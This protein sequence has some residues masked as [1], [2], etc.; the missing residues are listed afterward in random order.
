MPSP[1]PTEAPAAPRS[2]FGTRAGSLPAIGVAGALAVVIALHLG[3]VDAGQWSGDEYF[4]FSDLRLAG[5]SYFMHRLLT[6]SPRPFSEA[7]VFAYYLAVRATWNPL[8]GPFLLIFWAMLIGCTLAHVFR[9]DRTRILPRLL[10]G[11]AVLTSFLLGHPVAEMFYWPMGAA[12]YLP[13]LA[14]ISY[15]VVAVLDGRLAGVGGRRASAVAL[16]LAAG[17]A[18]LGALFVAGLVPLLV[19]DRLRRRMPL[20]WW[21]LVPFGLSIWVVVTAA[22]GRGHELGLVANSPTLHHLWPS[23]KAAAARNGLEFVRLG[24]PAV[25]WGAL[26]L[27]VSVRILT[28]SG[29]RWCLRRGGFGPAPASHLWALVLALFAACF[30]S[31]VAIYD[32][33]GVLCCERQGTFRECAYV[34]MVLALAGLGQR[35]S[36][37]A[38]LD[39]TAAGPAALLLAALLALPGRAADLVASYRM[40][41]CTLQARAETWR[42][43]ARPSHEMLFSDQSSPL[44]RSILWP[45]G[46]FTRDP[47]LPWGKP[48]YARDPHL[49]LPSTTPWYI[50]GLLSFFAKDAIRIA[51]PV[52]DDLAKLQPA[53]YR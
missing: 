35:I 50:W 18:E 47:N 14:G 15:F 25:G 28:F 3:L 38:F 6:W 21:T 46:R 31:T 7:L 45:A 39:W 13:C 27:G 4:N 26:L 29:F 24:P 51:P 30:V 48:W 2:G 8:I 23:A 40:Y 33:Y 34:L 41:P 5:P 43:A 44:V 22:L 49:R 52:T 12:A 1:E 37:P 20:P 42:D 10:L 53:R 19:L 17:S 32:R 9:S 11:V 16:T 36:R